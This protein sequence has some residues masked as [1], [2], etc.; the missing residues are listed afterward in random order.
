MYGTTVEEIARLNRI[1]DSTNIH[2]GQRLA[3]T[4]A[5]YHGLQWPVNGYISSGFGARGWRGFHKG[6]DI[7]APRGTPIRA[8][9]DGVVIASTNNLNGYSNYGKII[10]LEH[11]SGLRTI[12]A[13]NKNNRVKSRQCI[14]AGQIIGEVGA[15]G[16]A[17][18]NHLHFEIRNNG[19]A[20]DPLQ[21]LP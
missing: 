2:I 7:P 3:I 19:N 12:Y 16:N 4:S 18:G 15:T 8:A 14:R 13:H 20:I 17:T 10:I 21:Y 11:G 5:N 1:H 9:A 6:I